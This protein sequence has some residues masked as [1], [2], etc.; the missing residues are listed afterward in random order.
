M[1]GTGKKR[2]TFSP[3]PLNG[4]RAGASRA[5]AA[6]RRRVRGEKAK[7]CE[8]SKRRF[9]GSFHLLMH[10][11]WGHEPTRKSPLTPSPSP[12]RWERVA[13]RPGEGRFME[14]PDLQRLDAHWGHEPIVL[15]LVLL[16]VLGRRA[17]FSGCA[18]KEVSLL[19]SAPTRGGRFMGSQH[20]RISDAQRDHEPD[21]AGVRRTRRSGWNGPPPWTF[22]RSGAL[23]P[24][25]L[26]P[27][28]RDTA[29]VRSRVSAF[30]FPLS[31]F[32]F[33]PSSCACI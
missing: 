24:L 27:Q 25:R 30:G 8:F 6:R 20:L 16:L 10:A 1:K 23:Q 17:I 22:Q 31:A 33:P 19:T 7:S 2:L 26:V 12:I 29:A 9:M 14:S 11:N 15:V 21:R 32:R 3:S 5:V 4:E 13:A 28:A 18:A